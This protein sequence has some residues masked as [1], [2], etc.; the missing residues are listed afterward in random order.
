MSLEIA[1]N[2]IAVWLPPLIAFVISTFTS[3][4]GISGAFLLLPFQMSVLGFTSPAVSSTNQLYNIIAIPSGVWRYIKE[5]RM[6]WPLTWIV[7]IGTLPGVF[8]GA[9]IRILYLPDPV[10]FKFFAGLVLLYIGIRLIQD[11]KRKKNIK[12]NSEDRFSKLIKNYK[13]NLEKNIELPRTKVN[14]FSITNMEYEFYSEKFKVSTISIAIISFIVGIIGGIYGIGGGA[15]IAPVFVA[16]FGLPVYTIAGAALMGTFITSIAGV[17]FYQILSYFY[18]DIM[19]APEWMLGILFGI[20]G[21][22]GMY[23]GAYLQ[24]Y[25]PAMIIKIILVISICF[26]ALKYIWEF[27]K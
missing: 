14:E 11:L 6:V 4:G 7:V 26:I 17:I 21:F 19:I 25:I 23:F 27:V 18:T 16:F 10:N 15:I 12:N 2:E 9:F 24:K 22:A 1:G 8:L 3:M 13:K 5:G 20:G